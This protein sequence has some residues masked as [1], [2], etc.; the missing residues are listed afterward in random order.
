VYTAPSKLRCT[1]TEL[2]PFIQ[3]LRMPECQTF[4]HPISPVPEWKNCR[5]RRQSGTGRRRSVR[6]RNVPVPGW[7]YECRNA[8]AVSIDLFGLNSMVQEKISQLAAKFVNK[9]KGYNSIHPQDWIV[10]SMILGCISET[11]LY[12]VNITYLV[13]TVYTHMVFPTHAST[14]YS[15]WLLQLY[16]STHM[17]YC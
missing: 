4:R 14:T 1:L 13:I 15:L 17:Q 11:L 16:E 9:D 8:D 6:Y 12:T 2:P 10:Q 5:C 3:F 7:K